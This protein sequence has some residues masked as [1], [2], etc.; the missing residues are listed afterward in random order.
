MTAECKVLAAAVDIPTEG[1][2]GV[3]GPFDYEDAN[4]ACYESKARGQ[5]ERDRA[6]TEGRQ[7][8]E[9]SA[10]SCGSAVLFLLKVLLIGLFQALR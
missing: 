10:G 5:T 8:T 7:R 1:G 4:A 6:E 3:S 9:R 2:C